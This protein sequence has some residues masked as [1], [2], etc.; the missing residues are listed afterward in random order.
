MG[1]VSDSRRLIFTDLDGT[2][3]NV[4][5]Y[6]CDA[7]LPLLRQLQ[8]QAVP[9]I[10]VTS[11]TRREV[12]HLRQVL[13]LTAPFIVENGSAFF[14]QRADDCFRPLSETEG[15]WQETDTY[16]LL[17]L[18]CSYVEARQGLRQ[19][20][21]IIGSPLLG[22]GDLSLEQIQQHTGL[23]RDAAERAKQREF[24]EPFITPEGMPRSQLIEAVKT[25]GF[26]TVVG[27]RF[28]HLIGPKAGK[29][30]AA[31]L[32]SAV[33]QAHFPQNPIYTIGLGNSPNDLDLLEAVDC[34]I[35]IPGANGPHPAL[36]QQGWTVAPAPGAQGW[37][38]AL[39]PLL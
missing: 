15:L 21:Q 37:A 10:P 18:G 4:D 32:L 1:T 28:C 11:K 19:V 25:A 34:A 36:T 23:S 29:G 20:A 39:A 27:D 13:D 26:R 3:L 16:R 12:E 35:V 30:R 38:A 7:A 17:Q 33:Y 9:I 6:R 14:I 5:D 2:L 8:A 22:F 24:T 31:Q